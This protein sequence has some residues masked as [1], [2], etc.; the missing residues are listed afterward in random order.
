MSVS[1]F[2]IAGDPV[3][4]RRCSAERIMSQDGSDASLW[5]VG[6]TFVRAD[7]DHARR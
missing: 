3:V 1:T 5:V 6:Y 7:D 2:R 4:V